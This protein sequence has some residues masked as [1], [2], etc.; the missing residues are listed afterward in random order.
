MCQQLSSTSARN[1]PLLRRA[2]SLVFVVALVGIVLPR[3][4]AADVRIANVDSSG[5]PSIR[6]T[7]LTSS[8]SS[9]KPR[10]TENGKSVAG[11]S[12]QNLGA[13]KSVVLA[14]DRSRSMHGK[15]LAD[16]VSAALRFL[17]TKSQADRVAIMSFASQAL[18]ASG[19]SAETGDAEAALGVL[20]NDRRYGTRLYDTVVQASRALKAQHR[21]GRVL[22]LVTDGQ[23]TT[24]KATLAQ[25]VHAAR[26]AH[27]LVYPVA[28]ESS[29]FSPAPLRE[30][31]HRTGGS[32]YGAASSAELTRIYLR[33]ARELRRTWR[34]EYFTSARPGDRVRVSV[35]VPAM[36]KTSSTEQLASAISTGSPPRRFGALLAIALGLAAVVLGL[37][38]FPVLALARSRFRWRGADADL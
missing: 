2:R 30:L 11:L 7:V 3:S 20:V 26:A 33:I 14:V 32:Y 21:P 15:A 4:A 1:S 16:A 6:L 17:A 8:T 24:S 18:T 34:L 13:A 10:V 5:L 36:G 25:A 9:R 27:V 12:A 22:V 19:F 31:A 23:E 35:T 28:I 38:G 29:A 37:I